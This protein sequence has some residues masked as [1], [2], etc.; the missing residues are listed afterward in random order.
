MISF[1][2]IDE[3][4]TPRNSFFRLLIPALAIVYVFMIL[5]GICTALFFFDI[6]MSIV[7][8]ASVMGSIQLVFFYILDKVGSDV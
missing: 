8:T 6:G 3:F 4:L 1:K 7:V 5:V 2:Q